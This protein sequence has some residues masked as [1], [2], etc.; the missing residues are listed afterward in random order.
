MQARILIAGS[1]CLFLGSTAIT[2]AQGPVRVRPTHPELDPPS[3]NTGYAVHNRSNIWMT[4]RNWGFLGGSPFETPSCEFPRGSGI[5]YLYQGAVWIGALIQQGDSLFPR[6]S[7]GDD[8]W[9]REINELWPGEGSDGEI[10][11]RSNIPGAVNAQGESIYSP[12]ALAPQEFI[13][14]STDTTT[15]LFFVHNDPVDGPHRPLGIKIRQKSMVWDAFGFD[16][17]IIY[18][19]TIWNIGTD[20]LKNMYFGWYIDAM[21][22]R[23][24]E[25]LQYYGTD[26]LR[27]FLGEYN[28]ATIN[29]AYANDNDGRPHDMA[30]GP[31]TCPGVAGTFLPESPDNPAH[32]SFN[33]WISNANSEL[34]FGPCWQSHADSIGWS[35]MGTLGTPEG[36]LRKYQVMTSREIDYDQVRTD[37]PEWIAAHPQQFF[38]EQ[39]NLIEEQPW[40][41]PNANDPTDIAN[42]F[43]ARYMISWGP[44]GENVASPGQEPETYLFPGDSLKLTLVYVCADSFHD[45]T[46]P[47]T[48]NENIDPS[49][50]V[51]ED[52]AYNCSKAQFLFDQNFQNLPPYAPYDFHIFESSDDWIWLEWDA[53]STMPSTGVNLY[54]RVEGSEYGTTPINPTP[55]T[56]TRYRDTDITL[57][58]R[59]YYKAQALRFG[60]LES[61][62]S[63]EV[64]IIAGAPLPPTGLTAESSHNGS[65]PLSWNPN[66]ESDINHYGVYRADSAGAF[67]SIGTASQT[68]YT[69]NTVTNGVQ[70]TYKISAVDNSG[71][72]SDLSDSI[73]A[74]PMGFNEELLIILHHSSAPILEW[75]NGALDTF[76][77]EI[78]TDIGES[79]D[80]IYLPNDTPIF[81]SLVEL[82]PY[83]V[84]WVIHD[85]HSR[86][87]P[88]YPSERD[89]ILETYLSL[90]GNVVYSGRH[91]LEGTFNEF[92][93]YHP[94]DNLLLRDYFHIN[95]AR[96]DSW[97][98]STY[99]V[100]FA[101]AQTTTSCH[102]SLSVDSTKIA[103]LPPSGVHYTLEVDGL[104][105]TPMGET[106][107]TYVS[108]YPDSSLFHGM[109]CGIRYDSTTVML[110]FPLYAMEPYDSVLTLAENVL[111]YVRGE[112][113]QGSQPAEIPIP[114]EYAL[115]QNY[116]N[117]F[118][119]TT[120]LSFA[121]PTAS[122]ATILVY[123]ILGQRV[124][125]I[126]DAPMD[127]GT[128]RVIFDAKTLASG[129]YFY[130]L[131]VTNFTSIRKMLLLK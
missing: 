54:R 42:G 55:L 114:N 97:L 27:G 112:H 2:S 25:G 131:D 115:Y 22:G 5:E 43:H 4:V 9:T 23:L 86:Q 104:E 101:S 102:P 19:Y 30:S 106:I 82:S 15:D 105:P 87:Y 85:T 53:Y 20:T 17:F 41:E 128:H 3:I 66:S 80:F 52:L 37:M 89:D 98:P 92:S 116:P 56:S 83:Q 72:E 10:I 88:P 68:Q 126:L 12:D 100:G 122:R 6:V 35:W 49:K 95:S 107:Y 48:S 39:G 130:K 32:L 123:N 99:P 108:N 96:V 129:V 61:Y 7:V 36:D 79:P 70:Y 77:Q 127:A 46:N 60:T 21:V 11:E 33:W 93:S 103:Q 78:F 73:S 14:T 63:P 120:I 40:L 76:Y 24:N 29:V 113:F 109:T 18:D 124:A 94:I 118:N 110:T 26:D 119:S 34:D 74:I 71:L 81:P 125:T 91:L 90:G 13:A 47:Q 51:Y 28:G 65:V 117:P 31:F 38:D 75:T 59:Y 16:D 69:D 1:M 111:Q 58:T 45:P 44:L 50:Y 84:V 121:L 67:Q 62:Y 57:G 8:G 64:T